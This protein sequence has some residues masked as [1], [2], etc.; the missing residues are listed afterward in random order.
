QYHGQHVFAFDMCVFLGVT[1]I[2]TFLLVFVTLYG[3]WTPVG[4]RLIEGIQ[5][6]YF[7]P[8]IFPFL[9]AVKPIRRIHAQQTGNKQIPWNSYTCVL[10]LNLSV[11]LVLAVHVLADCI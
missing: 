4:Y 6:R 7:L 5:G 2:L 11:F 8:L 3:Q 10:I 9:L 1:S